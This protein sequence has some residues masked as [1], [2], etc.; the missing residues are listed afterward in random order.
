MAKCFS[1][2]KSFDYEK[3]YGICPKCGAYNRENTAGEEHRE[4]HERYDTTEPHAAHYDEGHDSGYYGSFGTAGMSSANGRAASERKA[5][6]AGTVIFVLLLIGILLSMAMPFLYTFGRTMGLGADIAYEFGDSDLYES[7]AD[8]VDEDGEP[9]AQR[10]QTA[11]ILP[12]AAGETVS[13]GRNGEMT[14]TVTGARVIVP[15]GQ[16]SDFPEGE[17]LVG[18]AVSYANDYQ[19]YYSYYALDTP[20]VGY[21]GKY[22]MAVDSYDVEDYRNILE[23]ISIVD[24]YNITSGSGQGEILVFVPKEVTSLDFYLESRDESDYQMLEIYRIPLD[25]EPGKEF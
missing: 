18:I 6:P 21:N 10:E 17:N 25:V 7:D 20:Y 22:K 5:S 3:Y 24:E 1:C 15:A 12:A 16:V 13:L 2:G 9:S 23:N 11:Q 14:V 4:L 8:D 19:D